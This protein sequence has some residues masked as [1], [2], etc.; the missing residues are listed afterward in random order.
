MKLDKLWISDFKNLKNVSI[1]FDEKS[2]STVLIGQN[3]TGKS[4]LL[5]A[6][7]TIFRNLD[8]QEEPLF[9]YILE[10]EIWGKHIRID[11]DQNREREKT[12]VIVT[13]QKIS[14]KKEVILIEEKKILPLAC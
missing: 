10:Y 8:L 2:L 11:S 9:R 13:E 12:K 5:E 3:G 7:A 4:N 1:D 14:D 6:I